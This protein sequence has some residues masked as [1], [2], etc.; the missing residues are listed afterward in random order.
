MASMNKI[1]STRKNCLVIDV[2]DAFPGDI[3]PTQ[4]WVDFLVEC[5]K[6]DFDKILSSYIYQKT[7]LLM[8]T[9]NSEDIFQSVLQSLEQGV[10]WTKYKKKVFGWSATT[11]TTPVTVVNLPYN[12]DLNLINNLLS[13]W[14]TIT[15]G[16]LGYL[17]ETGYKVADGTYHL[18]M[19]LKE[20]TVLPSVIDVPSIGE[21]FLVFST[22][23]KKVCLNCTRV[24]HISRF[25]RFQ[26]RT[27]A[28]SNPSWARIVEEG[29]TVGVTVKNPN[30][31][32][33]PS[34]LV[35]IE[36]PE[37]QEMNL[38]LTQTN[39]TPEMTEGAPPAPPTSSSLKNS[40][41]PRP[42]PIPTP[43]PPTDET[44]GKP[45]PYIEAE[46]EKNKTPPPPRPTHSPGEGS[47]SEDKG[48]DEEGWETRKMRSGRKRPGRIEHNMR[49]KDKI[50]RDLSVKKLKVV[51]K[52]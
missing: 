44:P 4:E 13:K 35:N 47:E 52:L 41:P 15:K 46:P 8:V 30:P 2:V 18:K 33:T 23:S 27:P 12:I 16:S 43:P 49:N 3:V 48:S 38:N 45:N 51:K 19:V 50:L 28:A 21:Q 14:G 36:T 29:V 11:V 17:K 34:P 7:N 32:P 5:L 22:A 24:G 9:V 26:Q 10:L 31:P 39:P 1:F 20:N 40:T 6:L 25:C 37:N 42:L